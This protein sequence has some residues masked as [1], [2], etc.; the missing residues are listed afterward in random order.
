MVILGGWAF[1]DARGT[2]VDLARLVAAKRVAANYRIP[3]HP[4]HGETWWECETHTPTSL[5]FIFSLS[6]DMYMYFLS[7]YVYTYLSI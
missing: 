6:L 7:L 5:L 4:R 3:I 1:P 2:P